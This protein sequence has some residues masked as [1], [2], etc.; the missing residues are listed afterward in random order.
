[1]MIQEKLKAVPCHIEDFAPFPPASQ[2]KSW[3][4]LLEAS[5][6]RIL[7]IAKQ[8]AGTGYPSLS[9]SL[10][11]EFSKSGNRGNFEGKYFE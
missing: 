7:E 2:R 10:Y 4:S 3:E 5:K 9:A 8:T 11:M 1:M 6:H